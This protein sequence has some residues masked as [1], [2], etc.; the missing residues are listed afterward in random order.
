MYSYRLAVAF[1]SFGRHGNLPFAVEIV[2][3]ERMMTQHVLRSALEHHLTTTHSSLRTN[4]YNP[5]GSKHH[6]LVVL[7]YHHRVAHIAQLLERVDKPLVVALVQSDARLVEDIEYVDELRTYLC[8][9]T[10]TLA[11]TS[12]ERCRLSVERQIV[13]THIQ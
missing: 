10:Y 11:L 12:R 9:K 7:N 2:G 8:G 1:A 3:C 13:E 6:V 4:V 5:V